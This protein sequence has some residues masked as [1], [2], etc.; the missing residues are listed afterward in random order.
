MNYLLDTNVIS[1]LISK[2][3]NKKVVEWLDRLDS[4]TIYLSV[5]TIGEIR[6]GIEKLPSSKRKERIKE[7]L[8]GDLLLRFQGRILEITT[9]VML[10]WGELTGR[11]KKEG[12]PITAIDSLIAAIALQGNYRLVTRNEHDFQYTGVTIIN[13]WKES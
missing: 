7:W 8:E 6:K 3:S 13:P 12:R 5:I 9:E 10:I 1:E 11:L 4:N 2:R